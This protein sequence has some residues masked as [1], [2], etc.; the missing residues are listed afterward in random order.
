MKI[1]NLLLILLLLACYSK[2]RNSASIIDAD[3]LEKFNEGGLNDNEFRLWVSHSL[4]DIDEMYSIVGDSLTYKL[5]RLHSG[6]EN[7]KKHHLRV[8]EKKRLNSI[9]ENIQ[10]WD[11]PNECNYCQYIGDGTG[12]ILEYKNNSEY[13]YRERNIA[14]K[15]F[16]KELYKMV[17]RDSF[18][19]KNIW[20]LLDEFEKIKD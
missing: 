11:A 3:R 12:V 6:L 17:G 4:L 2:E 13:I 18:E 14:E 9:V 16:V 1:L 19:I 15:G 5:Y 8:D 7:V 10:S 20:L